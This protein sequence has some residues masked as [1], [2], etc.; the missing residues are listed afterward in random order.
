MVAILTAGDAYFV[1]Y[2]ATLRTE[3][4]IILGIMVRLFRAVRLPDQAQAGSAARYWTAAGLGLA[5]GA[6]IP[7]RLLFLLLVSLIL[8]WVVWPRAGAI[9]SAAMAGMVVTGMIPLFTLCNMGRFDHFVPLSANLGI[10]LFSATHPICGVRIV[11]ILPPGKGTYADQIPPGLS[12]CDEAC[13]DRALL[14]L[15]FLAEGHLRYVLL[16]TSR[17]P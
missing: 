15:R 4:F 5:L 6:T 11:S 7:L 14:G 9:E 17:V 1:C 2:A 12:G 10:A 13:I 8:I 3:P 16:S